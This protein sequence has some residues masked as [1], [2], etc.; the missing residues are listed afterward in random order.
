[1]TCTDPSQPPHATVTDS[2]FTLADG[3]NTQYR[4]GTLY[5]EPAGCMALAHYLLTSI[6][7]RWGRKLT[8]TWG[9]VSG[10]TEPRVTS[11]MDD[12]GNT[13]TLMYP[14]GD[15]L[16]RMVKDPQSRTHILGYTAV[17][18]EAGGSPLKLTSVQVFGP[19]DNTRV[20]YNWSFSYA[21]AYPNQNT[22]Y[23][24]TYTGRSGDPQNGPGG[25]HHELL[26][27]AGGDRRRERAAAAEQ[28]WDGRVSKV[29]WTDTDGSTRE[30]D[31]SVLQRE[32]PGYP[33]LL[34]RRQPA[35]RR[36]GPIYF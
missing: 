27:R 24:G 15:G 1:M 8:I 34:P 4:F 21:D 11:V 25:D 3:D 5:W 30:I 36:A 17:A 32:Q 28:D 26:L 16:L 22:A 9:T 20:T 12:T 2:S 10:T 31:R 6:T 7:D 33:H 19:G 23:G 29:T 14:N 13:L 18:A 35:R